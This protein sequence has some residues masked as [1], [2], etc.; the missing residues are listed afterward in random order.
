MLKM[1]SVDARITPFFFQGKFSTCFKNG[2]ENQ[3]FVQKLSKNFPQNEVL[4]FE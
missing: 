1:R 3:F 4:M 2:G